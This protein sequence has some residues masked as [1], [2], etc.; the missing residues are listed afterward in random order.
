MQLIINVGNK[1]ATYQKRHGDLVCGNSDYTVKFVFDAEWD[2]YEQK[3]AR[4]IW[5]GGY[6]D[7]D[8]TGNICA[9]PIIT[10]TFVLEVGVFAGELKTTTSAIIP[11]RKSILCSEAQP[12]VENDH[13]YA[14]E[15]KEAAK[16]AEEIANEAKEAA[17]RAEEIAYGR[18]SFRV[19]TV[20]ETLGF[21]E[22]FVR[23]EAVGNDDTEIPE[24][25]KHCAFVEKIYG[26]MCFDD[27]TYPDGYLRHSHLNPPTQIALDNGVTIPLPTDLKQFGASEYDYIFFE[28]GKAFYHQGSRWDDEYENPTY[29]EGESKITDEYEHGTLIALA[30]PIIT[31]ISDVFSFDGFIDTTDATKITVT[32]KYNG[33]FDLA[34]QIPDGY[35]A[36]GFDC[37][38]AVGGV[39]LKM[40][41]VYTDNTKIGGIDA[42]LDAIIAI[43]ESLI[44]G[45]AV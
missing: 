30:E 20:E 19:A 41:K 42:A 32:S 7:V 13:Y 22:P 35:T 36:Y 38:Y 24:G 9:V 40:E 31:D 43:Q 25:V 29:K 21:A 45:D 4:F 18:D 1:V 16:R 34:A 3:T 23:F 28:G 6:H 17:K 5:N 33:E 2:A 11:C 14:N 37:S 12:S 26:K 27:C 10:G 8:F 15:A 44:G 39:K